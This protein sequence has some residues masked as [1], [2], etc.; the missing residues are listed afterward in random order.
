VVAGTFHR[1][2]GAVFLLAWVSLG[3]QVRLLVGSRGLLPLGELVEALRDRGVLSFRTF[4]S[5]LALAPGD[6]VLVGGTVVGAALGGLALFGVWP[7]LAA[8]L[9]TALYLGYATACRSF[10]GFQWDNLLLECGLLAA[11]LPADRKAPVVHLLFRLL[12][13]KLYLE[14]GFAKWQSPIGDWQD[15]SAMTFYYETAPLPTA[16]A[17]QAH[18][19]PRWWHLLESRATLVLELGLPI[20]AFGPRRIRLAAAAAFT[21]FQLGNAG[22]GNYGFFCYLSVALHLFLVDDADVRRAALRLGGL[23]APWLRRL[24]ARLPA[25]LRRG[26]AAGAVAHAAPG[27]HDAGTAAPGGDPGARARVPR[28][29]RRAVAALGAS[30]WIGVSLLEA[31]LRFGA[32]GPRTEALLPVL[33]LA[34]TFRLV[35]TYHLFAS[36]TRERI[37]PQLEALEAGSWRELDLRYKPGDPRRP[38][39]F[40]AP[41]QPRVDFQLWFYGL[42]HRGRAPIY[43]AT[44]LG[45]MCEDPDA[46]AALFAAAPPRAPEAVRIRFW[47]YRFTSRDEMLAT[48]AYWTRREIGATAPL[49]CPR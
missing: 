21:L 4:P 36:V 5:L 27:P 48:R 31:N 12:V 6:G 43:V 18:N 7:R 35:N 8:A 3:L 45:R 26:P 30:A 40:V 29:V 32:P 33:E 11:F 20:A 15:G 42:A 46:V 10:L 39:P 44:L 25:R 9:S 16:L 24:N 38:P 41:H 2:L 14:S 49:P 13:C 17:W 28:S 34:Q 23:L 47:D 1:A 37:E 22:T 19:L